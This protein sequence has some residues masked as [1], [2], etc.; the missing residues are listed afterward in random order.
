[1][2]RKKK[3]EKERKKREKK[4]KK[5]NGSLLLQLNKIRGE[6]PGAAGA[7]DLPPP[8]PVFPH[9]RNQ[10]ALACLERQLVISLGLTFVKC[11]SHRV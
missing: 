2:N 7:L 4:K 11:Q 10:N 8:P 1:M 9:F 6:E 3:K 5:R